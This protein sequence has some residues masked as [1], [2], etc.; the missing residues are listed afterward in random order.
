MN[1]CVATEVAVTPNMH[2][3]V[4]FWRS[5]SGSDGWYI[6]DQGGKQGKRAWRQI[7]RLPREEFLKV[8]QGVAATIPD[9]PDSGEVCMIVYDPSLSADHSKLEFTLAVKK[10]NH[11]CY[12]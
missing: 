12:V 3:H 8:V 9:M 7:S 10:P 2:E 11:Q 6:S 5:S 1:L 4:A